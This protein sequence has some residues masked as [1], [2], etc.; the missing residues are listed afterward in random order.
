MVVRRELYAFFRRAGLDPQ[1]RSG[2]EP[3]VGND[4]A[5]SV[6]ADDLISRLCFG[7]RDQALRSPDTFVGRQ[8]PETVIEALVRGD[9]EGRGFLL[10]VWVGTEACEACSLAPEGCELGGYLDDPGRLPDLFYAAL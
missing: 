9:A 10:V 7:Y 6:E 3:L 5:T 8:A 1:C 2:L 4:L